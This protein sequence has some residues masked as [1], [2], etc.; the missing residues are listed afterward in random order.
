MTKLTDLEL[1]S[2]LLALLDAHGLCT[3]G[4]EIQIN[5]FK[6]HEEKIK[7]LI[8]ARELLK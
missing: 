7:Q 1:R 5:N 8:K 3:L 4:G 6:S 2:I